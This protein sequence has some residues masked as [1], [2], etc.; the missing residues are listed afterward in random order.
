MAQ[1]Y[2]YNQIPGQKYQS[3]KIL[4]QY[5]VGSNPYDPL[6]LNGT[7]YTFENTSNQHNST[8][9]V[10]YN[11]GSQHPI[12]INQNQVYPQQIVQPTTHIH[13]AQY[14]QYQTGQNL[15]K[16]QYVQTAAYQKQNQPN[17]YP[18]NQNIN[19]IALNQQNLQKKNSGANIQPTQLQQNIHP[20]Q[21]YLNQNQNK[22]Q[23]QNIQL[24]PNQQYQQNIQ[25]LQNLQYQQNPQYQQYLQYQQELQK[26]Q[27]QKM[28]INPQVQ[29]KVQQIPQIHQNPIQNNQ[30][31]EHNKNQPQIQQ[32]INHHNFQQ[33]IPQ[34][35]KQQNMQTQQQAILNPPQIHHHHQQQIQNQQHQNPEQNKI[36]I[37]YNKKDEH[38]VNKP[39]YPENK[40]AQN[41]NIN[42]K[43]QELNKLNNNSNIIKG[44][45]N[46]SNNTLQKTQKSKSDKYVNPNLSEIKEEEMDITQSGLSQKIS[47]INVSNVSNEDKDKDKEIPMEE[48]KPETAFPD[49]IIEDNNQQNITQKSITESGISDYDSKLDHLPT[50]GSILKGA[51]DPLP[52]SKKKKY[53]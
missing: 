38:F 44:N 50:I 19:T 14:Y 5:N 15:G 42:Q 31:V 13:N 53:K 34:Q 52:P 51:S 24:Q 46:N 18:Q 36:N 3:D 41:I 11:T 28:Q 10:V 25:N 12:N 20:Q 29:N 26:Q 33:I 49:N 16:E 39:I 40:V 37:P 6:G 8:K 9:N 35:N 17:V 43:A 22:Y 1:Q 47:K 4:Y 45:L 23:H 48:K 27:K 7:Q 21:Q 30:K 2:V 32:A